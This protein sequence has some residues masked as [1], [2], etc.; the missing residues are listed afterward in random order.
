VSFETR[1]AKQN[2]TALVV[3]FV[4]THLWWVCRFYLFVVEF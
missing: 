4:R 2:P 1:L 3:F